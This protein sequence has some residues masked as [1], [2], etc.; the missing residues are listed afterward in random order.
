LAAREKWGYHP[1]QLV[2]HNLEGNTRVRTVRSQAEIEAAKGKVEE[3]AEKITA[4]KFEAKPGMQCVW[5]AYRVL[6]PKTEKRMPESVSASAIVTA[7]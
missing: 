3:I 2:F 1:E 7:N 5:C 4:G 6:C